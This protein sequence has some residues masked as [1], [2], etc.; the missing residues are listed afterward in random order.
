M[1][2]PDIIALLCISVL[3]L[4]GV[5]VGS[6]RVLL[7]G[8]VRFFIG[9]LFGLVG[10]VVVLSRQQAVLEAAAKYFERQLSLIQLL[11]GPVV[12]LAIAILVYKLL[13]RLKRRMI[14]NASSGMT[15]PKRVLGA[16]SGSVI[17]LALAMI[18][19]T[20]IYL[21]LCVGG[22]EARLNRYITRGATGDFEACGRGLALSPF[23]R[24]F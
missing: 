4:V 2:L 24:L 16:F 9:I 12:V 10:W 3:A 21:P 14:V 13:G 11:V 5:F 6:A 15:V 8:I 20:Q 18:I 17:G 22:S 19:L 23:R 1:V 7:H